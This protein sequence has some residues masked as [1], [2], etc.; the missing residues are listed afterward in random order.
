MSM[1]RFDGWDN[2]LYHHGIL[3]MKWGIRRYQNPDGTWKPA[4]LK[5]RR[6]REM[7]DDDLRRGI[8][9]KKL[10]NEY[11]DLNRSSL[12]KAAVALGT[13]Y[14]D[15]KENKRKD[16]AEKRRQALQAKQYEVQKI[17][18]KYAYKKSI[19]DAEKAESDFKKEKAAKN[20]NKLE[21]NK[22]KA[23]NTVRGAL[24]TK[25]SKALGRNKSDNKKYKLENLN[26]DKKIRELD[27][28]L[29]GETEYNSLNVVDLKKKRD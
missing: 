27:A 17:Q 11:R 13:R 7:S 15:Y 26:L 21:W 1:D 23:Q 28:E 14:L 24:K 29:N 6:I 3:G 20:R 18:A 22:W 16:E 25:L 5:K 19:K 12:S 4:G 8:E 10:E 9:R 2:E